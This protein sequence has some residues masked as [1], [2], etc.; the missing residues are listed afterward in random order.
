[1]IKDMLEITSEDLKFLSDHDLKS[2]FM[3]V[4]SKIILNKKSKSSTK[5]LEIVFCFIQRELET[6]S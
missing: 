6:R 3:E 2:L 1:M 4:R 5:D